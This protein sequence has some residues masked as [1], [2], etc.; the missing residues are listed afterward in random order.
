MKAKSIV[1][2]FL[3]GS[4]T[5]SLRT[6]STTK[7]LEKGARTVALG[8]VGHRSGT[9]R[10]VGISD[11][12]IF[13]RFNVIG[14]SDKI[15]NGGKGGKKGMESKSKNGGKGGKM[16]MEKGMGMMSKVGKGNTNSG[17]SSMNVGAML[18]SCC[19]RLIHVR[20]SP[21]IHSNDG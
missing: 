19:M 18:V 10:H 17:S 7:R 6:Q 16:T 21:A 13:S 5:A 8:H 3:L 2:S 4:S 15:K 14:Y 9:M 12:D 20:I 11:L 1:I